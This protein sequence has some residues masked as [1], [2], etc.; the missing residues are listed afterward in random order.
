MTVVSKIH[1]T[2]YLEWLE[3][4]QEDYNDDL[5]RAE[6]N[7]KWAEYKFKEMREVMLDMY[8]CLIDA[9]ARP[10]ADHADDIDRFRRDMVCLGVIDLEEEE[11]G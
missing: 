11:H 1:D 2:E 4:L 9:V 6:A 8:A 5:S 10:R 7:L 3:E